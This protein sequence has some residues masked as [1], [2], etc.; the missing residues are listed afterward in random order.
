MIDRLWIPLVL[1]WGACTLPEGR[2]ELVAEIHAAPI[3][4]ASWTDVDGRHLTLQRASLTLGDLYLHEPAQTR[5]AS[6]DPLQLLIGTA[7]AHPGHDDAGDVSGELLGT[8]RVDLLGGIQPLGD[9]LVYEGA[10]AS[11]TLALAPEPVV[12]EGTITDDA[13]T[14]PFAF[15]ILPDQVLAGLPME[16]QLSMH[17]TPTLRI[18][19]DAAWI[20]SF[21]DLDAP[22]DDGDGVLTGA[23]GDNASLIRFGVHSTGGYAVVLGEG[24][25]P[26]P[27][28]P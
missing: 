20:L 17:D 21:A 13:G 22:D 15:E 9:A 24:A 4:G 18:E 16:A 12:L 11:A 6:F 7:H 5:T 25:D 8:W 19:I 3:A 10:L 28:A 27:Q 2:G 23:D 1:L 14:R 26:A